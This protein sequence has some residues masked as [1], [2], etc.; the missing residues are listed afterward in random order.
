MKKLYSIEKTKQIIR[1]L[2]PVL[3]KIQ[4]DYRV[5]QAVM[6][7]ILFREMKEIDLLDAAA[8]FVVRNLILSELT[9]RRDCST[10]YAQIYAYVAINALNFAA[11]RGIE[12]P[13]RLGLPTRRIFDPKSPSDV[14]SIWLRLNRDVEF[15]LRMAALNVLA[16]ADEVN[17]SIDLDSFTADQLKRVFSRYNANTRSITAYGEEVYGYYLR[18]READIKI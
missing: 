8:D 11:K 9:G 7:A 4:A 17:G 16:A 1:E 3:E 14:R 18:Y 12:M 2:G 13:M 6:E 15:N 5:P 10:G